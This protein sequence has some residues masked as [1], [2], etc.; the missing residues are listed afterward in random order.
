VE[1]DVPGA[2]LGDRLPEE[3]TVPEL[4]RWLACR[5][6]SRSGCKRLIQRVKDYIQSG[7]GKDIV[8][9]DK[10]ESMEVKG[11]ALVLSWELVTCHH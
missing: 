3:L 1:E 9:P 5:G 8:D 6:A 7:M 10:A 2:A 4:Q 11:G